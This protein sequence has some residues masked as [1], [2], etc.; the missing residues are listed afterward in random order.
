MIDSGYLKWGLQTF[1]TRNHFERKRSLWRLAGLLF[2]KIK[3]SDY[4]CNFVEYSGKQ[5]MQG[6]T[7]RQSSLLVHVLDCDENHVAE[8]SKLLT[9]A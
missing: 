2:G 5:V 3:L 1:I 8:G 9:Y 6:L 7:T 4:V